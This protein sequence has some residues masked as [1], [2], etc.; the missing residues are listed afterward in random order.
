MNSNVFSLLNKKFMLIFCKNTIVLILFGYA[1]EESLC[2]SLKVYIKLLK[3]IKSMNIKKR[4]K[5]IIVDDSIMYREMLSKGISTDPGIEVV[6][7]ATDPY[8]AR[9]KII[10]FEPDV[11]ILDVEMP[12]MNG[13]EF[14]QK[15]MPQYPLPVIVVSS[16]SNNVFDA[17][18]AGA[19]DF[20]A[21]PDKGWN[22]H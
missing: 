13:I 14:L 7:T 3:G 1:K 20:A 19:V 21:K 4:I 17:L 2:I 18:N 15:L 12:R 10:K 9:D 16:L 22:K 11:M 5:V 8:D 6:A